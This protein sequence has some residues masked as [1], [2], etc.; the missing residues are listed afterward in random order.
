MLFRSRRLVEKHDFGVHGE[1]AHNGYALPLSARKRGGIYVRLIRKTDALQQAHGGRL[2]V[3]FH[4]AHRIRQIEERLFLPAEYIGDFRKEIFSFDGPYLLFADMHGRH[5]DVL[6][7]GHVVEQIEL[8]EHHAHFLAVQIDV[9]FQIAQIFAVKDDF[10]RRRV[11][12][13]VQ[14]L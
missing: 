10:A 3:C 7:H 6:F 12:E 8:L 11:F 13:N 1:R 5:R 14:R 4:L 2:G 9:D